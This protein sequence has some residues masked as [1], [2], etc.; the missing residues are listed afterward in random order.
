MGPA[1]FKG[2]GGVG[3]V[4]PRSLR[5]GLFIQMHSRKPNLGV[6]EWVG[7]GIERILYNVMERQSSPFLPILLLVMVVSVGK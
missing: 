1:G 5:K 4:V 6:S 7:S 3:G 2:P